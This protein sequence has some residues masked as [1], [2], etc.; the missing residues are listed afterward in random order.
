M[1]IYAITGGTG[2]L[3]TLLTCHLLK[4]GHHVR[5]LARGERGHLSL[6]QAVPR[7]HLN[8]LSSFIGDVRDRDRLLRAFDGADYVIH[9]AAAKVIPL[10]EYNPLDSIKTN[11]IGTSNVIDACLDR[12]VKRAVFVSS[13]KACSPCT[14]YGAQKLTAERLWLASNTYCGGKGGIFT[15]VRYGNCWGSAG[16]ILHTFRFQAQ[17]GEVKITDE[18]CTRF[19]LKLENAVGLVLYALHSILAGELLV[20]KLPSYRVMDV[21]SVLAPKAEVKFIGLRATEKIHE[22]MLNENESPYATEHED[23]YVVNFSKE[24]VNKRFSYDSGMNPWR[25]TREDLRKDVEEWVRSGR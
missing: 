14:S 20:P 19:H 23:H 3:G 8:N 18:R 17:T 16:S 1:A 7:Q 22:S 15:A 21:A 4:Q 5:A 2:S 10:C 9:A 11:V 24:A 12:G 13:D 6:M 25:V